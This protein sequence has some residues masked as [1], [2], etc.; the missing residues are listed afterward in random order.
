M[1]PVPIVLA[2]AVVKAPN[3][4]TSPLA[5]G[6]LAIDRRMPV[7]IFRCGM[8]SLKVRNMCVPNNKIIMGHP[9]SMALNH[10]K[11]TSIC[12]TAAKVRISKD[13][14]KFLRQI[15]GRM[16]GFCRMEAHLSQ[17]RGQNF[18]AFFCS[19]QKYAY[20]CNRRKKSIIKILKI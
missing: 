16:R 14:T 9:H 5:P 10:A 17:Q 13:K 19:F 8:R 12:S 3:W 6:S 1:L 4:L 20:L 15:M 2:N 7:N 11:K 18:A